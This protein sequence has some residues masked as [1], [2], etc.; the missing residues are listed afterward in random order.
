M[1]NEQDENVA[2][3]LR[4]YSSMNYEEYRDYFE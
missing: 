4:F 1:N 3:R 2:N